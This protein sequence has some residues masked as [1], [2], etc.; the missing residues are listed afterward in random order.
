MRAQAEAAVL[1]A[2]TKDERAYLTSAVL[3]ALV[4]ALLKVRACTCVRVILCVPRARLCVASGGV[5]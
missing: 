2:M 5:A 1:E 4:K 3:P